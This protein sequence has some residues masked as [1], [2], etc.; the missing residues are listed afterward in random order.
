MIYPLAF[1][2]SLSVG[3][4]TLSHNL[5]IIFFFNLMLMAD[6][7]TSRTKKFALHRASRP[8]YG[9]RQLGIRLNVFIKNVSAF[10]H[11]TDLDHTKYNNIC[12]HLPIQLFLSQQLP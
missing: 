12:T 10:M 11:H 8:P 2:D 9:V 6:T 5:I 1:K 7:Y 4:F 3:N